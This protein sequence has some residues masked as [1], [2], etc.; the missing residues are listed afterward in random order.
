[1]KKKTI[2][3]LIL[4]LLFLALLTNYSQGQ[5]EEK[6][7]S[8]LTGNS[9]LRLDE[10]HKLSYVGG[11]VDMLL[12]SVEMYIPELLPYLEETI[13][14]MSGQQIKAIFDKYLEEYPEEWHYS[15]ASIFFAV[16]MEMVN[17]NIN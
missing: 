1:M 5:E 8:F 9:Y 12:I 6:T 7:V 2:L 16:I 4:M 11:L 3:F 17:E 10:G 14:D 13:K 15:A